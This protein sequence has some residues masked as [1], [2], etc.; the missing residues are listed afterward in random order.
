MN[1]KRLLPLFVPVL[2]WL[3]S[4]AFLWAP[5][6]FYASLALG[7]LLIV[8]SLKHLVSRSQ[9][10]WLPFAIPPVLFFLSF[11]AYTAIIARN[12]WIQ[13][14]D[15]ALLGFMFWYLRDIYY[16]FYGREN[17]RWAKRLDNLLLSGGFLTAF[18]ASAF[19]F[20]LSVFI[21]WP[22]YF[23]L[24]SLAAL[25]ACLFWQFR[26]LPRPERSAGT[27]WWPALSVLA[28]VELAGAFIL[29]PLNF[30]I[31]ALFFAIFY[32]LGLIIIRLAESG[33][34]GRRAVKLPLILGVVII[35]ALLLTSRWL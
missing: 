14:L 35:L 33:G 17:D 30:N 4:Q 34:L 26:L 2:L 7:A 13:I 18:T 16:Y 1:Y 8:L 6:F 28:L 21:N 15:I 10:F 24:P 32:Y 27:A 29:L 31:L 12:F 23:L 11:S 20:D 3:L 22:F 19:L 9:A 5:Y 25:S